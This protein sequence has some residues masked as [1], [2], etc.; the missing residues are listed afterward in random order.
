[1]TVTDAMPA[2]MLTTVAYFVW[3]A[4]QV[5]GGTGEQ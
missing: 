3:F 1:M 4:A 5:A 2:T